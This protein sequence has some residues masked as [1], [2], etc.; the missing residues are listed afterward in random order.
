MNNAVCV[1][2]GE[3]MYSCSQTSYK[4]FAKLGLVVLCRML[5]STKVHNKF[6][7]INFDGC[8]KG[9][10]LYSIMVIPERRS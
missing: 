1:F 9:L 8:T 3:F 2:V 7:P 5:K 10:G 6:V 4:L